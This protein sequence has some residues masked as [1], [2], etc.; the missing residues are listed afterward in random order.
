MWLSNKSSF[1]IHANFTMD[2]AIPQ[3][4]FLFNGDPWVQGTCLLQL[5][6]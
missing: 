1:L 2:L 6:Q 3:S 5:H 4:S